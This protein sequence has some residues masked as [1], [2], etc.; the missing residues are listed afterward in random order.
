MKNPESSL[1][2]AYQHALVHVVTDP[3]SSLPPGPT[4]VHVVTDPASSL[5]PGPTLVHVM[6]DPASFVWLIYA[7]RLLI[8]LITASI[9]CHIIYYARLGVDQILV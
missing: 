3:A 1:P 2:P 5:P 9:L 8:I 4:L 6:T 7:G